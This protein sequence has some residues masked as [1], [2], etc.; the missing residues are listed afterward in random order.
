MTHKVKQ[1]HNYITLKSEKKMR[2]TDMRIRVTSGALEGLH[3]LL[4]AT[5][6]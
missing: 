6:L 2:N 3:F 1:Q 4:I 5:H